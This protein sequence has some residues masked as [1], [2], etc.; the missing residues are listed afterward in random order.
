M[1]TADTLTS[2][3]GLLDR[4]GVDTAA[5]GD[6]VVRTPITGEEIARVARTDAAATDAAIARATA[7]F[8]AWRDLP[9][10]HRGELVRLFGEELRREKD[11]LGGL[12]TLE[13]GK[14]AQ[15]G[16]GEV[17]EMIDICDFAVGLS[18][19]LY[20]RSIA[21]ERPGHRLTETWHPLG[22]VA[23]ISAFNFPVAV[24]SWNAAL[25]LVCGDP[26][27]W[28]PSER[29]PLTAL[30]CSALLDRAIERFG[31]APEGLT[32]LVI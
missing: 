24:W 29:T 16:L 11:A 31:G 28:K 26:V 20:G 30:A 5:G 13:V 17:Q 9:G 1:A 25:A 23:V 7:A 18:R 6:L 2:I 15:E 19:Q 27:I 32:E 14:I 10:P 4:L 3:A 12:V 22:P 8:A 21:S